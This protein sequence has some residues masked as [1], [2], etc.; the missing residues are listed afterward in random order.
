M[1]SANILIQALVGFDFNNW[2]RLNRNHKEMNFLKVTKQ[3]EM[4][5]TIQWVKSKI[6]DGQI[7]CL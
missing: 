7:L 6:L 5:E 3:S 2:N 4:L 1:E